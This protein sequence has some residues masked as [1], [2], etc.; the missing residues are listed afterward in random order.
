MDAI[1][2]STC[3]ICQ[4]GCGILV[5]MEDGKP[6]KIVG[7]PES[8][9]NHGVLCTKGLASLEYLYHPDRLKQPLQK[10]GR[11]GEGNWQEISW[12]EALDKVSNGLTRT[13]DKY[14]PESILF[15]RGGL[16]GLNSDYLTRFANA[17]G[18]PNIT[19]MAS[20]CFMPHVY[21]SRFTFGF[22][23]YP[24]DAKSTKCI[25]VWGSNP[26]ETAISRYRYLQRSLEQ[27]ASL[28]IIDPARIDLT[29]RADLWL[30]VRP[31]SDLAL[32]LGMI[33]VIVN[34]ELYDK[35]FVK[36]WTTGFEELKAHVKSYTPKRVSEITWVDADSIRETA[37]LYATTRP[38]IIQWGDGIEHN[39]NS[40]QMARALA[41]L[42]TITGNIGI[43]GGEVACS[44]LPLDSR[45]SREFSLADNIP[46]ELRAKRVSSGD[47]MLPTVFYAL[48]QTSIRAILDE[49]PYPIRAVYALAGNNLMTFSNTSESL[50]AFQKLD[51]LA[52]TDMFMTPT[53][54]LADIVLPVTTY[55]EHDSLREAHEYPAVTVQQKVAQVGEARSDYQILSGL[56]KKLGIGEYFWDTEEECLD[57]ILNN[58][59]MTFDNFR[60][61]SYVPA[62]SQYKN[63][64]KN[65]FPT[66]SGK[67]ELY[68]RQLKD[69]G[70]DPLPAY[71]EPPETP[72][73]N[74]EMLHEYPLIFTSYKSEP[75]RHTEGRQI[76]SL[77]RHRPEPITYLN[78]ET[79]RKLGIE[80]GDWVNIE[81]K[82]G[83]IRQKASLSADIDPRIAVVDYGWW[84]PETDPTGLFGYDRSNVNML[85]DNKEPYG[86]EMGTANLRGL[87]CKVYKEVN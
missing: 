28:I 30:K 61:V 70:F 44:A 3:G 20:V 49:K 35:G 58:A 6:Q 63:Y 15:M 45:T 72:Y 24:D 31:A 73:S 87:L 65:G 75:Y 86:R 10:T 8:P 16:R 4:C 64:E 83:K 51:F 34:E 60:K 18:T 56:A 82:R 19:S 81:T 25:L 17:L 52:V 42:K 40:F 67:A 38:A 85:T 53:A 27:G 46:K 22:F 69:W 50:E 26:R 47:G 37:R 1:V 54:A 48:P 41:I 33:N 84:F 36:N 57:H 77:R 76:P 7:D 2:K 13:M 21:A 11:R 12:D 39:I 78:P 29:D 5:H 71:H 80:D 59:G 32:A 66:P 55:L 43:P 14:G 23:P 79:A 68:S 9:V 62:V 74:S